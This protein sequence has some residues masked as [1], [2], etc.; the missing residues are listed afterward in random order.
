MKLLCFLGALGLFFGGCACPHRRAQTWHTIWNY[1]PVTNA[2]GEVVS[3]LVRRENWGD[4]ER[5]GGEFF[6]ADPAA[7]QLSAFHTNQAA[8]GGG[9]SFSA[10][11]MTIVVDTNTPAIVGAAG[12]AAGNI[13]G[14]AAK[15]AVK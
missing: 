4:S 9:S 8:L 3:L 10:G 6:L 11:T 7:G 13:I 2:A 15:S 14:A 12:T 5:G 1:Q